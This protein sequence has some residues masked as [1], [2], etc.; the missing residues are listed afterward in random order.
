MPHIDLVTGESPLILAMPHSGTYVPAK[1]KAQ[2]SD[3]GRRLIDT[4]WHVDLLYKD[5]AKDVTTVKANFHRYVIDPNRDPAG[6]S[7]YPGQN[8]TR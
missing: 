4:D 1:I 3:N 6:A 8:T 2:L 5:L 7:L